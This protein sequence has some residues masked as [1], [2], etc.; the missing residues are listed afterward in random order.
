MLYATETLNRFNTMGTLSGAE[1]R[2]FALP[3]R[4][5][6]LC[7]SNASDSVASTFTMSSVLLVVTLVV[8]FTEGVIRRGFGGLR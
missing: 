1:N 8:L 5:S 4:V 3:L 2:A 7:V 6:T